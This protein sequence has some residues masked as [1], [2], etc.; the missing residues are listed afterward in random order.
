MDEHLA[1]VGLTRQQKVNLLNAI[2]DFEFEVDLILKE[3][4][5]ESIR[6]FKEIQQLGAFLSDLIEE[7]DGN[8]SD[9]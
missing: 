2:G 9:Y 5:R 8:P 1:I 4:Q 7:T 6:C 3:G